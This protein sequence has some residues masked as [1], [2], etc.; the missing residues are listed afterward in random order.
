LPSGKPR[1]PAQR[2]CCNAGLV[3]SQEIAAEK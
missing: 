3:E 1:R 2:I